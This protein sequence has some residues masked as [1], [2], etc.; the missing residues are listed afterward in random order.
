MV[1]SGS[2]GRTRSEL[3]MRGRLVLDSLVLNRMSMSSET[4]AGPGLQRSPALGI[5]HKY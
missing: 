2:E 5:W 3:G 4:F 1:S